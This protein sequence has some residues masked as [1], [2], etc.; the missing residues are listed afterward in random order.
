MKRIPFSLLILTGLAAAPAVAAI[1]FL[2]AP[3]YQSG[4]GPWGIAVGDVDGDGMPGDLNCDGAVDAFDI[5]PFAL[6]VFDPQ[7]YG[8]QYP[9]C[10]INSADINGDGSVDA[11]DIEPFIELLFGP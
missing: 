9:N 2:V 6:A 5:E 3:E 8:N 7:T 10:D 1:D 4:L 11:F